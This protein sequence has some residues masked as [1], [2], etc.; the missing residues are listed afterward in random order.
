MSEL[1]L[2]QPLDESREM[3]VKAFQRTDG[4][5]KYQKSDYQVVGKTGISFPRV[6]WSYGENVYADLSETGDPHR[7]KVTVRAEKEVSLNVGGNAQKFKRRFLDELKQVREAS[8]ATGTGINTDRRVEN[9]VK[10]EKENATDST[11]QRTTEIEGDQSL[12][13]GK[14]ALIAFMVLS[15][16]LFFFAMIAAL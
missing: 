1:V 13:D 9:A 15:S 14:Q 2:E 8:K 7:T 10:T 6:L 11:A 5:N 4:I 16:L 12:S 3:V